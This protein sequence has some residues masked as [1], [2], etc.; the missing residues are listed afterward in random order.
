MGTMTNGG[1]GREGRRDDGEM[2][3]QNRAQETSSTSLGP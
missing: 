3:K 2:R 1:L